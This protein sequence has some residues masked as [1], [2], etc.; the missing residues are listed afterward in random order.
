MAAPEA[1]PR[2]RGGRRHAVRFASGETLNRLRFRGR[3]MAASMARGDGSS[4]G[5][6][7][8]RAPLATPEERRLILGEWNAT[9]KRYPIA[10][11][12]ELLDA[13]LARTSDTVAV[14][15]GDAALTYAEL[16]AWT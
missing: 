5:G 6:G 15:L 8:S 10:P 3:I 7:T 1:E 12:P 11:L 14:E 13:Q 4:N 2:R 16:H 9:A